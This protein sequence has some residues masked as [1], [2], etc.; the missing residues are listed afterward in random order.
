[1]T[2]EARREVL[3]ADAPGD[4]SGGDVRPVDP[5]MAPTEEV[6]DAGLRPHTLN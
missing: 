1:M 3:A 5:T 4:G 6:E 2:P